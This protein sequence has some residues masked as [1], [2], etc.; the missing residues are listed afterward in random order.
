MRLFYQEEIAD[1]EKDPDRVRKWLSVGEYPVDQDLDPVRLAATTTV[2]TTLMNF[3]EF[4][5]KR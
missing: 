5:M 1:F 4:V 3:D 2:A